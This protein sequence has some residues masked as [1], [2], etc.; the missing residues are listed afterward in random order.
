MAITLE[1]R[2]QKLEDVLEI[3]KLQAT[4]GDLVDKG[5]DGKDQ[6]SEK[7]AALFTENGTWDCEAAGLSAKGR[8]QIVTL[9]NAMR[10]TIDFYMH[11]FSNPIIDIDGDSAKANWRLVVGGEAG[12]KFNLTYGNEEIGYVRTA[13]GWRLTSLMLKLAR[14]IPV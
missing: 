10:G 11:C 14:V 13:A 8:D 3:M 4:Y 12:R 6:Q 1:E 5:W 2:V 9:F 7:V